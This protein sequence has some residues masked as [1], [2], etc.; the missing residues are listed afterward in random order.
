MTNG[1]VWFWFKLFK[2]NATFNNISVLW[3][4]DTS[5][6]CITIH[7]VIQSNFA[8]NTRFLVV[9]FY[10]QSMRRHVS[11]YSK[12]IKYMLLLLNAGCIVKKQ[13]IPILVSGLTQE[14]LTPQFTALKKT[15]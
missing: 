10:F 3:H 15:S 12:P 9:L 2:F 7:F 4:P 1:F 13:Q 5:S 6:S 11:S 8:F 14:G